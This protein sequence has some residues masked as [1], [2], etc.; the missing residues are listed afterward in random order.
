MRPTYTNGDKDNSVSL[1]SFGAA[2]TVG[3]PGVHC[4]LD[5]HYFRFASK[6]RYRR[7]F[8]FTVVQADECRRHDDQE[9]SK[10]TRN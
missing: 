7:L 2:A 6:E 4:G 8:R 10:D 9:P 1:Y 3:G 5:M